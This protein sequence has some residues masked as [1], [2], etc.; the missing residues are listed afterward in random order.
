MII[1]HTTQF[2]QIG[3]NYLL[4]GSGVQ[5]LDNGGSFVTLIS[6]DQKNITIVIET[7]VKKPLLYIIVTVDLYAFSMKQVRI[8]CMLL[9]VAVVLKHISYL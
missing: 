5:L 2:A 6:P 7:M 3:W 4:H 8:V 1:A 9:R